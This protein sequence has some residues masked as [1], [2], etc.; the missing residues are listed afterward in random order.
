[1]HLKLNQRVTVFTLINSTS[2]LNEMPFFSELNPVSVHS[3]V[4]SY[5]GA[6]LGADG[7]QGVLLI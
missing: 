5:I 7:S 3:H 4:H 6:P 1:M 2:P